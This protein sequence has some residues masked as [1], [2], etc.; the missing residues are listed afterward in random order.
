MKLIKKYNLLSFIFIIA[1]T[2]LIS[3]CNNIVLLNPK[4]QVG[5]NIRELIFISIGLMLIIVIP[6]IILTIF[7]AYRYNKMYS[8]TYD[9][10]FSHSNT[11]ELIIWTIPILIVIIL[12]IVTWKSSHILDPKRPLN[13]SIQPITIE[14]IALNWKWL[15]IYPKENIALINE[16]SFPINTPIK[17]LITSNSIMN[18]FFIPQLGSQI[19]AMAGMKT[20]L[21]IISNEP[22]IYKGISSNFSGNGFSGMKFNVIVQP[23]K[24]KFNK[25]IKK[26]KLSPNK[27][28]TINEYENISKDSYFNKVQ[29]FSNIRYNLFKYILNKFNYTKNYNLPQ[30]RE[31]QNAGNT[32]IKINTI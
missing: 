4:G 5:H 31:S 9:P 18:S 26:I 13:S 14:V 27:I 30:K 7:F 21:N 12:A 11:L 6:V 29:Y 3:G 17:F 15:F 28:N 16:L 23:N 1:L 32:N 8:N 20:T 24:D 22:G 19:Y 2:F 10:N 25:W